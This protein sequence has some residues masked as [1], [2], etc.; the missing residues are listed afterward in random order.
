GRFAMIRSDRGLYHD[1]ISQIVTDDRGWLWFG[2][3]RGLFK[4]RQNELEDVANGLAT[5]VQSVCYGRDQG[6]PPLQAAYGNWPGALRGR[7]GRLW[8]PMRSSLAVIDPARLR[9]DSRPVPVLLKQI[10]VDDRTQAYYGGP[11]PLRGK[12]P[13]G[14]ANL[15][16]A[17]TGLEIV[18]G[19]R[20][21]TFTY[22]ALSLSAPESVQFRYRLDGFDEEW[23]APT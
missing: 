7:D 2:C 5:T 14:R 10:T 15:R 6:L 9:S 20:R 12:I 17:S 22:A 13:P 23:S 8:I 21:L 1:D 11:I 4:V 3:D 18:P 19:Y 16:S